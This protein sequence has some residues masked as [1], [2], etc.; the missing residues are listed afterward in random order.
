MLRCEGLLE[1]FH[2][3]YFL[4]FPCRCPSGQQHTVLCAP[5]KRLYRLQWLPLRGQSWHDWMWRNMWNLLAVSKLTRQWDLSPGGTELVYIKGTINNRLHNGRRPGTICFMNHGHKIMESV[6][7]ELICC[8][9]KQKSVLNWL[10]I[11]TAMIRAIH[12]LRAAFVS[13]HLG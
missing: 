7:D 11:Q 3:K 12:P 10:G 6:T 1:L 4:L 5:Q 9:T 8:N 13:D 2:W